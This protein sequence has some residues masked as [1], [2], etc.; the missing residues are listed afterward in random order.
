MNK[1]MK[2]LS[3]LLVGMMSMGTLV[4]CGGKQEAVSVKTDTAETTKKK[5]VVN[6]VWWMIGTEPT[7][8]AEV[9]QALNTYT[10]EKI[11]VTID[12]KYAS[13]GEYSEK[14]SKI[15]Q[16][17]ESYD[18]AFGAGI[19][20]YQDLASKDY[21]ADLS[22]I[23]A[24]ETP[25]LWEFIPEELWKGMTI[26]NKI[27]GVPAYK[28]SA[29]AQYWVWDKELVE[30]LGI[31]YENI[32]TL[33]ELEPALKTIKENDPSGYPL[34]LQGLEG[35]NGFIVTIN[36]M[37]ELLS[38]P[39]VNVNFNDP[40]AKVISPWEQE[41]V[42]ENLRILHKWFNEG[43]INPDASTLI[44]NPQYTA[45]KAAQG[46]P[47]ADEDWS[48]GKYPM[49]SN[50]F[51]G[52]AYSTGTIQGSFLVVSE[53]SKYKEE[54]VKF[55]EL[56]NT[57]KYVRNLL[58]FGIEDKHYKKTG[59]NTIE[60]L[61]DGYSAPAYSQGTFFNMYVTDPA[62]ETKWQ[63]LQA[64]LEESFSSPALGFMF[65]TEKVNNQVAACTN[66]QDKYT[67]SLITGS[68]NPDEVVPKMLEELNKAGYQD[69][70]VE[71]Q[72]QLDAY[73]GK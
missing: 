2:A 23:L 20:N 48:R 49:V 46:Y 24:T 62:P 11:G 70:L 68:V 39:Y 17:G 50:K 38:K 31:D 34:M 30:K 15:I 4:G 52:P 67:P 1:K 9:N 72:A 22:P 26:N 35:I 6:L 8:L 41:S 51:F 18:M 28:D 21:F 43:L 65:N 14:L 69:I 44:E 32:N 59:E 27:F 63:D 61:N 66:I 40:S 25:A 29:Q 10:A 36:E 33:A 3:L 12:I 16:S 47:H 45:V 73:L 57:D 60:I 13:W 42:M 56:I 58:A 19:K 71:V 64:Q 54:A 5:E 37:D 7:E 55:I 53:G